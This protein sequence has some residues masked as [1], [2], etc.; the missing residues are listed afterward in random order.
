MAAAPSEDD[1]AQEGQ[2]FPPG[3]GVA[4]VAAVGARRYDAFVLRK[5]RQDDVEEAAEGQAQQ[6]GENGSDNLQA[7]VDFDPLG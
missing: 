4:A 2:I 5:P 7:D 1:P 6:G 3:E